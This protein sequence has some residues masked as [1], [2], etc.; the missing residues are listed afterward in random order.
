[1]QGVLK[2]KNARE[3][4][5]FNIFFQLSRPFIIFLLLQ[6]RHRGLGKFETYSKRLIEF[7][8]GHRLWEIL[9]K[10]RFP[11]I[12]NKY[13][14]MCYDWKLLYRKIMCFGMNGWTQIQNISFEPRRPFIKFMNVIIIHDGEK[15][16]FC[17]ASGDGEKLSPIFSIKDKNITQSRTI[18]DQH[19]NDNTFIIKL[20]GKYG[21]RH[22]IADFSGKYQPINGHDICFSKCGSVVMYKPF[23]SQ[24]VRVYLE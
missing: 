16:E 2:K 22:M 11:T 1:M 9:F 6:D 3:K 7:I 21:E 10:W 17:L 12:Y 8:K 4:L 24:Y 23:T 18:V 14:D 5:D 19:I 13:I 20:T 15:G